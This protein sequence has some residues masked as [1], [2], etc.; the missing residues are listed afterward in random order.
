MP[1]IAG[2]VDLP[3]NLRFGDQVINMENVAQIWIDVPST[4]QV[5]LG[6]INPAHPAVVLSGDDA[7]AASYLFR[8]YPDV[9]QWYRDLKAGGK[10]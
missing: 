8:R 3:Y 4:G 1:R 2:V 7:E 10:L 6:F 5:S 9:T